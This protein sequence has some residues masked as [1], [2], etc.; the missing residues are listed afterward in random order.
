MKIGIIVFAQNNYMTFFEQYYKSFTKNFLPGISKKFI[1]LINEDDVSD[2]KNYVSQFTNNDC[3]FV[4]CDM[5]DYN[6]FFINKSNLVTRLCDKS[7]IKDF[8]YLLITNI[9]INCSKRIEHLEQVY[10]DTKLLTLTQLNSLDNSKFDYDTNVESACYINR[11]HGKHYVRG[12]FVF[13][14]LNNVKT[15]YS[16]IY[17]LLHLDFKNGITPKWHDESALNRLVLGNESLYKILP[18]DAIFPISTHI[19]DKNFKDVFFTTIEKRWFFK[20]YEFDKLKAFNYPKPYDEM[21]LTIY[22]LFKIYGNYGSF[23]AGKNDSLLKVSYT[24]RGTIILKKPGCEIKEL[25]YN[26]NYKI[27]H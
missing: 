1:V 7:Y 21:L 25:F 13:G 15:L 20:N 11:K 19:Y 3:E 8:D 24:D 27:W 10:D 9:N 14:K 4:A 2:F 18:I 16:N 22:G 6:T 17:N 12:W 5:K 23:F 26:S